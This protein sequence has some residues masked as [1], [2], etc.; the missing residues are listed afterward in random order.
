MSH[1]VGN[2]ASKYSRT[3]HIA[4]LIVFIALTLVFTFSHKF[5][6]VVIEEE[7]KA[8]E[9]TI[10]K[11]EVTEQVQKTVQPSTVKIPVAVEDDEEVDEDVELEIEESDFSFDDAP[12]PPPPPPAVAEDEV[13]DFF[14][15]AEKPALNSNARKIMGKYISK[16][17][18]SMAKKTGTGGK[19]TLKFV[20]NKK[21]IPT[22][23]RI[24]QE[25][26]KDMGFGAV[27]V[28]ALK[29]VRFT[30]GMQRDTPVAV[31]MSWPVVFKI[32]K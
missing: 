28:E 11:V 27:A 17:Y 24:L 30:P 26:P 13:V 29:R 20:C 32:K 2:L 21:G 7:A 22:D 1:N 6:M 5:E 18:P 12:P 25:R 10:E 8:V 3:Q 4:T 19:V 16:N 9:I 23:I 14:A 31:R 15:I